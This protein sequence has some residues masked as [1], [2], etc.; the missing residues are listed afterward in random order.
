MQQYIKP[1]IIKTVTLPEDELLQPTSITIG[2]QGQTGDVAE[3]K[4]WNIF[5][6]T[7]DISV[8]D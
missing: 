5:D 8:S 4:A 3:T 1:S 7:E 6:E 2:G